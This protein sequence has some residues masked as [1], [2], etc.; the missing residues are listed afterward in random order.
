M[1]DLTGHQPTL[2]RFPFGWHT[3]EALT[4]VGQ[5]GLQAIQWD[6]LTGDPDPRISARAIV[7]EVTTEAQ[8][9]S[10]I[11]MHMNT[12]GWHTAEALPIVIKQLRAEGY[13]FVTVS[14]LLELASQPAS[15][16]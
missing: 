5:H 7:G 15:H 6:V 3:E 1:V 9:G 16:R 11:I 13:T 10:I 8:N 4:V 14:Q 12:W 2:F